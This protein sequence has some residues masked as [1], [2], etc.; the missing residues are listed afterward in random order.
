MQY[1]LKALETKDFVCVHVEAP[2]EAGHQGNLKD[3]I[4][5]IEDFDAKVVGPVMQGLKRYFEHK[6]MVVTDHPTPVALKTHTAAPV[7][8]TMYSWPPSERRALGFSE[9]DA[10]KTGLLKRAPG[11]LMTLLFRA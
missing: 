11:E 5:A 4:Q 1:A 8:Y 10:K 7:P 3:K 6:V 9:K 2:D